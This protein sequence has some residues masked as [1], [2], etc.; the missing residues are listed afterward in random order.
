MAD[1]D[2]EDADLVNSDLSGAELSGSVLKNADLR[3]A[4]LKNVRWSNL[5][6]VEGANM[7]GVRNAPPQFV[8]WAMRNKAVSE[9]GSAE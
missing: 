1:A 4:D 6:S 9:P 5:K 7:Y 8:E 2:L 3:N